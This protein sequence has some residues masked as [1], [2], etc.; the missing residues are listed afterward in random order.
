MSAVRS[1]LDQ[2]LELTSNERAKLAAALLASLDDDSA[3]PPEVVESAWAKE[4]ERR[5][6]SIVDSGSR[7]SSWEDVRARIEAS[8]R[9]T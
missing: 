6:D 2:A 9:A 8:L 1:V 7:G 5:A 3:D 4:L